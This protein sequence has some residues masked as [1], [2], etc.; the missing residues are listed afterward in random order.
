MEDRDIHDRAPVMREG[1]EDGDVDEAPKGATIHDDERETVIA[2]EVRGP[3]GNHTCHEAASETVLP[4]D[5]CFMMRPQGD[6]MTTV[7]G[8]NDS[9]GRCVAICVERKGARDVSG[10]KATGCF[11]DITGSAALANIRLLNWSDRH[12]T[13][14]H[15]Q[16]S[17]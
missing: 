9:L 17:R 2:T 1:E 8:V 16:G 10:V 13:S 3:D 6:P 5:Y 4:T 14:C 12:A 7:V 15:E 11:R